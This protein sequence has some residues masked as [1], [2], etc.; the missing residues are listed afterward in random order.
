ML[1]LLCFCTKCGFFISWMRVELYHEAKLPIGYKGNSAP[2][3]KNTGK[4]HFLV[5][6]MKNY[7]YSSRSIY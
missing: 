3:S 6:N 7:K 2:M 5:K 4:L 1:T